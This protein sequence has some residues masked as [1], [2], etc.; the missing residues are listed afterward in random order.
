MEEIIKVRVGDIGSKGLNTYM[1]ELYKNIK[2]KHKNKFEEF[3]YNQNFHKYNWEK[4]KLSILENGYNTDMYSIITV[5]TNSDKDKYYVMDGQHRVFMLR[6]MFGNDHMI[7]VRIMENYKPNILKSRSVSVW[8]SG[9][10]DYMYYIELVNSWIFPIYFLIYHPILVL[11]IILSYYLIEKYLPDN[12][13]YK[14][15][16]K[17]ATLNK[18]NNLSEP[19]YGFTLTLINNIQMILY[20]VMSIIIVLYVLITD[21]YGLIAIVIITSITSYILSKFEKE[22][23]DDK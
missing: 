7:D 5:H 11:I 10:I 16:K 23:K 21:F 2:P 9:K 14:K 8:L 20:L 17:N 18:I 6:E 19:L 13:M 3:K 1:D 12:Q 15:L 4:L 22:E